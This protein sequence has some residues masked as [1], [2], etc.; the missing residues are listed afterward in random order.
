MICI[1][2][3]VAEPAWFGVAEPLADTCELRL[4]MPRTTPVLRVASSLLHAGVVPAS[5]PFVQGSV[6][7]VR[8]VHVRALCAALHVPASC[9]AL[10]PAGP[11]FGSPRALFGRTGSRPEARVRGIYIYIYQGIQ[12]C[13]FFCSNT[14]AQKIRASGLF[15]QMDKFSGIPP[16]I[17]FDWVLSI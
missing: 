6:W 15:C 2:E 8:G 14:F 10:P 5:G 12:M 1:A 17:G 11:G 3:N 7:V 4:A 9:P 16:N 13:I